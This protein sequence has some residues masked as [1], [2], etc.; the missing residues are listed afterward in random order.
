[1]T[2]LDIAE[3]IFIGIIIIVGFGLFI[4]VLFDEKK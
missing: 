3:L 2:T 1:M 4:K